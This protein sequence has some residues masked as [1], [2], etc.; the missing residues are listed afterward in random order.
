MNKPTTPKASRP[1]M[2]PAKIRISGRSAPRLISKGR[3]MLSSTETSTAQGRKIV[4]VSVLPLQYSQATASTITGVA[5]I[6][7]TPSMNM[8]AVSSPANGTPATTSPMPPS[9]DC[10]TAVTITPRATARIAWP[11]RV[12][13]CSPRAPAS[14]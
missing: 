13:D 10:T 14:R 2:T 6:W 7:A 11:P 4:A 8:M 3:R 9:I 1:P 5:P 12:T